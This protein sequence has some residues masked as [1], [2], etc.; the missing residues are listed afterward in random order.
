MT[1][2]LADVQRFSLHDGPGIRTTMFLKGCNLHCPWCH[3]PETKSSLPQ[4]MYFRDKCIDCGRCA[5][6]CTTGARK[7][8]GRI[9]TPDEAFTMIERDRPFYGTD[10]GVTFSGGEA[11]LQ[12]AFLKQT[13]SICADHGIDVCL[14]TA[15]CVPFSQWRE[16]IPL[17]GRYLVDVKTLER[18]KSLSVIG[19]DPEL[20]KE[21]LSRLDEAGCEIWIRV[22]CV[23]GWNDSEADAEALAGLLNGLKHVHHA[24]ILPVFHHGKRKEEALGITAEEKWFSPRA[25]DAALDFA[26]RLRTK[27]TV[28]ILTMRERR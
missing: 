15:L 4:E 8:C 19:T 20:L 21:N 2:I 28:P 24:D 13:I 9:V 1:G 6:G 10:G 14:D 7:M 12:A 17:C 23:E 26:E 3:N 18:E 27:T 5:E 11:L 22:P 25:D 16:L